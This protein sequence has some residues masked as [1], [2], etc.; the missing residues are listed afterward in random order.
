VNFDAMFF[1]ALLTGGH[2]PSDLRRV[3]REHLTQEWRLVYDWVLD[4]IRQHSKLPRPETVSHTFR[5]GLPPAQ[6]DLAYYARQVADNALRVAMEEGFTEKV[7]APL[8]KAEPHQALDGAKEVLTDIGRTFRPPEKGL[9]LGDMREGVRARYRDY[10]RR[11]RARGR[12]GLPLPHE[13]LTQATQGFL[14][15]DTWAMLARPSIGK[16]W[17]MILW[18]VY[19]WQIGLNVLFASM[20]TPP[21]SAPPDSKKHR[22]VRGHCIYCHEDNVD[23]QDDCPDADLARQRLTIRFDAIAA[24]V[25]AWRFSQGLL[26]PNENSNLLALYNHLEDPAC[27]FGRLKIVA[28][29]LIRSVADL[30]MEIVG[31]R[32][33]ITFWDSAYLAAQGRDKRVAASNLVLDFVGLNKRMGTPGVMSWHFNRDV[34]EDSLRASMN[35]AILTDE[36]GRACD[37]LLGLFR[38]PELAQAGEAVWRTIKVR[39]G[40]P[41]RELKTRFEVKECL[42]FSEIL[43]GG[44]DEETQAQR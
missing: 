39:D 14:G 3:E 1:S 43:D 38:P 32:P 24:R 10:Q 12:Q 9:S 18:A 8:E 4:F 35:S 20:E 22:V 31:F 7:A 11:K 26:T 2:S 40:L 16:T 41:L 44:G 36:V 30:E 13:R 33:D 17:G 6:D 42:D 29:P 19:L 25:S 21:E 27:T 5:M 28:A 34:T 37:V 23:P 15:G